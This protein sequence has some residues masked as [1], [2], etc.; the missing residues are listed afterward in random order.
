MKKPAI[1]LDR[2]G[3]VCREVNYLSHPEDLKT[4]S[5][6]AEAI[7]YFNKEF[8]VILITNQ[9]GIARGFFDENTLT[10]I[11][12]KLVSVLEKKSAIIDAVYFCP[13][14]SEDFCKCRK[15]EIGMLIQAATDFDIDLKKSWMIGDKISDIETGF[16]AGTKTALV[17]TGYGNDELQKLK[18]KPDLISENLLTVALSINKTLSL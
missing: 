13:H 12:Q 16:N 10:Q 15:P 17:L 1:F 8:L 3:T 4:F 7:K 6:S 14:I 18:R 9:S 5:F 11:N 2:D